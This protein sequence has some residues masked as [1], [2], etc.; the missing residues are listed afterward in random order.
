MQRLHIDALIW[1]HGDL[2]VQQ[3]VLSLWE[4]D[5]HPFLQV[6]L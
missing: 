3:L 6:E 1:L 2:K 4:L 5:A